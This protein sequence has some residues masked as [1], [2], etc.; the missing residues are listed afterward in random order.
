[1]MGAVISS[2][3]ARD[4][5][6]FRTNANHNRA[7]AER[8]RAD[9]AKA[10]L[11]GNEASRERHVSRGKLLPATGW[12]SCWT[13]ARPFW[14]LVSSPPTACMTMPCRVPG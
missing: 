11:G 14:R 10:G 7:L 9:V 13:P 2:R 4:D 12:N 6:T 3:I 8:L 5:A 1:M